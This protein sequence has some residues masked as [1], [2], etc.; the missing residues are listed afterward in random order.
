[1]VNFEEKR[2]SSS[3]PYVS[4][5]KGYQTVPLPIEGIQK[6]Y[7]FSSKMILLFPADRDTH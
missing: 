4:M 2:Y 5:P 3:Y 1:M 6:G 7:L